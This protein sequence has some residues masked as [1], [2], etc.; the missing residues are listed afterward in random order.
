M[1]LLARLLMGSVGLLHA[2][3]AALE[4]FFFTRPLGMRIFGMS[5][6]DAATMQ[7]LAMNQGV[8]NGFLAAGLGWAA[9]TARRDLATFFLACVMIAGVVG[10]ITVKPSIAVVQ[11]LPALVAMVAVWSH[12]RS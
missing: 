9:M 3:F 12:R 10:A 11:A 7:A 5:P 1:S 8:Y 4:M 6:A 2:G